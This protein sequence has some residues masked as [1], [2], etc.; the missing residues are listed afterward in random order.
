MLS[1]LINITNILKLASSKVD[2][3]GNKDL[4]TISQAYGKAKAI[5]AKASKYI[6]QY[7]V[8]CSDSITDF[9]VALSIA[10][11]VE[12]DCARFYILASGLDPVIEA[13]NKDT[14][15]AHIDRLTQ[16]GESLTRSYGYP[17]KITK[18]S[19]EDIENAKEALKYYDVPYEISK[20]SSIAKTF[21]SMEMVSTNVESS[22]SEEEPMDSNQTKS[23]TDP[24]IKTPKNPEDVTSDNWEP[25]DPAPEGF[26]VDYDRSGKVV[27]KPSVVENSIDPTFIAKLGRAAPTVI[28][29]ELILND[30]GG[31][32]TIK[33][34][35][36]FKSDLQFINSK[37]I[38]DLLKSVDNAG[39]KLQTFIKL[40]SG[41]I[42]F[43]KDWLFAIEDAKKDTEK[44]RLIGRVPI[45]RQLMNAK[46]TYRIKSI[47]EAIPFFG[48]KLKDLIAKKSQKDLP[49]CTVV[50]TDHDFETATG[51]PLNRA[52]NGTN[53]IITQIL[54]TYM[55]LG[56]GITDELNEVI[57]FFYS[58]EDGYSTV[59]I[60]ELAANSSDK[61]VSDKLTELLSN[62]SKLFVK[63]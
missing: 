22:V 42:N 32:R 13:K 52:L 39:K 24:S 26:I 50:V 28:N 1:D 8:A 48:G 21:H 60:N 10:K 5:S 11:Q 51:V 33:I 14:I 34:P 30:V 55:L 31:Q 43:F 15:E 40:T 46:M 58:G 41:E 56:F 47:V 35:L 9:K 49:M 62:M 23:E 54:D 17:V 3:D 59:K 20:P 61:P 16:A 29:V 44:E 2:K 38:H 45:F 53:K 7:P 37:D 25:G 57:Y 4:K 27:L 6:L 12:L 63:R 36:A 18:A 19:E